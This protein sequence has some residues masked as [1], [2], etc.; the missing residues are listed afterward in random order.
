M[1]AG[2]RHNHDEINWFLAN[3]P[4]ARILVMEAET[5]LDRLH[6]PRQIIRDLER[7]ADDVGALPRRELE[8]FLRR[9]DDQMDA[10]CRYQR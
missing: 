1:G 2:F 10:R 5:A 7:S 8:T 4:T 3:C 9:A 6:A